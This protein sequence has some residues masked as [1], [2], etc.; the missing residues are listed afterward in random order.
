[1]IEEIYIRDLGVIREARLGFGPGLTVLTGETGAGKTMVLSALGLLLGERA[2]SGVVRQGQEQAFVEGRWLL[3][4]DSQVISRIQDAGAASENGEVI[5]N[6]SVSS[7]GRSRAAIGGISTPIGVLSEIGAELVVVH[8][9][10]DQIRLKSVAAQR[11]ALDSYAGRAF[12]DLLITYRSH[13]DAWRAAATELNRLTQELS[14]RAAEADTLR[15][16]VAELERFDPQP[17]EDEELADRANRLTH[18][19]E[20][21]I[22][23]Q[24]AHDLLSSEGFDAGDAI[25]EI[26][27]A[28]RSLEPVTAHD[29]RLAE[30]A[31]NLKQ[32]GY[33]L[34]EAAADLNGYLAGLEG[35]GA[36]ELERVQ[37]RRADLQTLKRKYGPEYG[38]VLSY[39]ERASNRLLELDSSTENIDRLANVVSAELAEVKR[40]GGELSKLRL[41]AASGLAD[42]VTQEL[43]ALAM[44]G[45]SLVVSVSDGTEYTSFGK[46]LVSIQLSAYPGAEPRPLGKGAS[47]GELSR[48][49]LAIEVVLAKFQVA[50]TFIFDEV[51]AGVGGAAAIEVGRRLARLAKQSQVIVVTHLA[52]VAAFAGTHLRVLKSVSSEYTASDV[53]SLDIEQRTEELARMLSGLSDSQTGRLHAAELLG[54]ASEEKRQL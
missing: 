54:V 12:S 40:L 50:P 22:A 34:V 18:A 32:L 8:G 10:A 26:G 35:D 37:A 5:V 38:E 42:E 29:A 16:A 11:E 15:E 27:K 3:S 51:D 24:T 53:V 2:E 20:I 14:S 9:Q 31:E 39:R 1:M 30:L 4:G 23:V 19:E 13:F 41:E 49:M 44:K 21:R 17:N 25:S 6:R 48:I 46:D 36:G 43:E 47:G 7:E 45:A 52:Q 33:Q 28:R